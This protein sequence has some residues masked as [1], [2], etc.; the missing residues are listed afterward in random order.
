MPINLMGIDVGFSVTR[1]TTGIACLVGDRLHLV[2]AGTAWESRKAKIPHGFQPSHRHRRTITSLGSARIL[3][4]FGNWSGECISDMSEEE[5]FSLTTDQRKRLAEAM[6]KVPEYRRCLVICSTTV[7]QVD[8]AVG[9][10]YGLCAKF[11]P[12]EVAARVLELLAEW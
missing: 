5:L 6:R 7:Y 1:P 2:R 4:T 9:D 8:D 12:T 10:A 3:K 11:V